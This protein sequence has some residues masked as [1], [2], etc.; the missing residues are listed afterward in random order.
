[1]QGGRRPGTFGNK[2]TRVLGDH[3]RHVLGTLG[4]LE[5]LGT[6]HK[7][8]GYPQ[9]YLHAC[10]PS[11]GRLGARYRYLRIGS[12]AH[13]CSRPGH[14]PNTGQLWDQ[15]SI[16]GII[17]PKACLFQRQQVANGWC[18]DFYEVPQRWIYLLFWLVNGFDDDTNSPYE[19]CFL[20]RLS[21][22]DIRVVLNINLIIIN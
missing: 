12:L 2:R 20:V 4:S 18:R 10:S 5:R 15:I 17:A 9:M 16:D 3:P 22:L 8:T 21:E 13:Y 1:M 19:R 7:C 6:T 14:S 11:T